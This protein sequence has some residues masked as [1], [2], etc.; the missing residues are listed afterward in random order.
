[1]RSN[2]TAARE[3]P[4]WLGGVVLRSLVV[5]GLA[6]DAYVHLHLAGA[7]D[8]NTAAIS[9]GVLF[10][11]EAAAAVAAALLVLLTRGRPGLLVAFLVAL[12][13]WVPSCS[14]STW[15]WAPSVRSRTCTSR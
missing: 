11:V 4:R 12:A 15:T 13:E 14:T 1:M 9:Q 6:V 2:A 5:A 3:S 10:R 7:Y 8:G